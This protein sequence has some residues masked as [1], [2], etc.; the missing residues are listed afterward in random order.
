MSE[1]AK[2]VNLGTEIQLKM[3]AARSQETSGA[4]ERRILL[5]N[6]AGLLQLDWALVSCAGSEVSIYTWIFTTPG[7]VSTA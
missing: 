7:Y 1:A 4:L 5:D 3:R 2:S 6:R